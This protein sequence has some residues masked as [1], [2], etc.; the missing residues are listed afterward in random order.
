M[1]KH[2][3]FACIGLLA[4]ALLTAVV[5]G[6]NHAEAPLFIGIEATSTELPLEATA[7]ATPELLPLVPDAATG[8]LQPPVSAEQPSG[9]VVGGCSSQLCVEEGVEVVT[10]CEWTAKYSCYQAATCERQVTGAC[11]WTDTPAL[12]QCLADRENSEESIELQN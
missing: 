12:R 8:T 2:T 5:L 1:N 9:C 10:T 4:A 11:G 7:T 3:I 6:H